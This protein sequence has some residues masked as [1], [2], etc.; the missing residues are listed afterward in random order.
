VK[1]D[2][3]TRAITHLQPPL[4]TPPHPTHPTAA[5]TTTNTIQ[6]NTSTHTPTHQQQ[7]EL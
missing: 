6:H 1:R 4:F 5:T 7:H 2:E 3:Q